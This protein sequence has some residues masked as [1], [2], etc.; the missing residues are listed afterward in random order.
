MGLAGSSFFEFQDHAFCWTVRLGFLPEPAIEQAVQGYDLGQ[1]VY[2]VALSPGI[3]DETPP[4]LQLLTSDMEAPAWSRTAERPLHLHGPQLFG[5]QFQ[6]QV[7]LGA[8]GGAIEPG[9]GSRW[10]GQEEILDYE[11]LRAGTRDGVVEETIA[12]LSRRR[13]LIS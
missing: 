1:R 10:S 7:Y 13:D 3:D 11:A 6:Q 2:V 5:S 9:I 8:R 4:G 12:G